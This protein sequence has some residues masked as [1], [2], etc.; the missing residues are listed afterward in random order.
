MKKIVIGV[1]IGLVL[2]FVL[3]GVMLG[4]AAPS[5]MI[6]QNESE[7]DFDATVAAIEQ[8][9]KDS[10]WK[11]PKTYRL[12]KS[13]AVDGYEVAPVAI[14]ELCQPHHAAKILADDDARIVTPMMPCRAAVYQKSDGTVMVARMNSGLVSKFFGGLVTEVMAEAAAENEVIF[15]AV[16]SD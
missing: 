1:V 11:V 12:D 9:A 8:A 2:G 6:L 14:I 15:S 5:L 13:V 16:L 7:M 10:G 4:L 3:N